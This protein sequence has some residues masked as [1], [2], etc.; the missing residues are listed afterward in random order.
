MHLK[1]LDD[2]TLKK[3]GCSR[4]SL[5]Y[6]LQCQCFACMH[7]VAVSIEWPFH[8]PVI[9][10]EDDG[11]DGIQRRSVACSGEGGT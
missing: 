8:C 2:N 4:R 10:G 3:L 1:S 5:A 6:E 11:L 7:R 9:Y